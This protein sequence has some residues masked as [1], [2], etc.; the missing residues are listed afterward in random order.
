M[1]IAHLRREVQLREFTAAA[2]VNR[3]DEPDKRPIKASARSTD[4]C[5]GLLNSFWPSR[6]EEFLE[7]NPLPVLGGVSDAER[8]AL[9]TLLRTLRTFRTLRTLRTLPPP[10]SRRRVLET[11]NSEERVHS[12]M[13]QPSQPSP[14]TLWP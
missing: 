11:L 6:Y 8:C 4:W 7:D 13:A 9:R 10:F 12:E 3:T 2:V 5:R 1:A 14:L